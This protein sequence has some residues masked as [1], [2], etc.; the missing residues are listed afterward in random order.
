MLQKLTLTLFLVL[1]SNIYL[2]AQWGYNPAQNTPIDSGANKVSTTPSIVS[3][4]NNGYYLAWTKS[5]P[6]IYGT[7]VYAQHINENGIKQWPDTGILVC[8]A[9]YNQFWPKLVTDGSGGVIIVWQ[10][11]RNGF[12]STDIYAQRITGNGTMLWNANGIPV[13]DNGAAELDPQIISDGNGGAMIIAWRSLF[14]G[15]V[16]DIYAQRIDAS[17]ARL[18]GVGGV[19]VCN[20][21]N[22]QDIP[23]MVSDGRGGAIVGWWDF[24]NS[25]TNNVPDIYAQRISAAGNIVWQNNGVSVCS[26]PYDQAAFQMASDNNYGAYFVWQDFRTST[27]D[28]NNIDIYA[29]RIDS[30]G[31]SLWQANGIPVCSQSA[32]QQMPSVITGIDNGIT[33]CWWDNRNNS[34]GI[35]AQRLTSSGVSLWTADGIQVCANAAPAITFT[36]PMQVSDGNN[37]MY[38]F[39][40]NKGTSSGFDIYAQHIN[41]GGMEQWTTG[42]VPVCNANGDQVLTYTD[43]QVRDGDAIS[44]S[45]GNAIV[46]WSDKRRTDGFS[47]IYIS[48]VSDAPAERPVVTGIDRQCQN[49][50]AATAKLLNPPAAAAVIITQDGLPIEYSPVDSSF[51]YFVGG[52]TSVGDHVVHIQYS[53]FAGVTQ[54]DST[55]SVI[56]SV[57]K[58][59][60]IT[61]NVNVTAGQQVNLSSSVTN[62]GPDP[63]LQW[64]ENI[65][66]AGWIDIPASTLLT[67]AYTPLHTGDKVRCL[68]TNSDLCSTP[69]T[70]ISNELVFT[71]NNANGGINNRAIHFYPN[72]AYSVLYIDSLKAADNWETVDLYS[73]DGKKVM[74][75]QNINDREAISLD[76][77][78]LA[79]GTYIVLLRRKNGKPV[80]CKLIKK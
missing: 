2:Q 76:L 41:A 70:A 72:P 38:I 44:D 3:D 15:T 1:L 67:L 64:Q 46:T 68:L 43:N 24:R 14:G 80:H 5:K 53:N 54:V 10:D 13:L 9:T 65:S 31:T 42:G 32:L 56:S 11:E 78:R 75:S 58:A 59:I 30:N 17:G 20:A 51:I 73:A 57:T 4:G 49:N 60:T 37:G 26:M 48:K 62:E 34:A 6:G 61:G 28:Q 77:K 50:A 71:V 16:T 40:Q 74:A 36:Y 66:N 22:R 35:Y 8:N 79:A 23:K 45:H 19:T 39:W 29:Q 55:Y 18:W 7:E 63:Q 21:V 33:V 52:N 25:A 47:D 69:L 27:F 12:G